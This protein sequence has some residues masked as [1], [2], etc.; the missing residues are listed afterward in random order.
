MGMI[1]TNDLSVTMAQLDSNAWYFLRKEIS[2]RIQRRWPRVG[3][4]EL[5]PTAMVYDTF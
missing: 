1:S 3:E 2:E 4:I 5:V